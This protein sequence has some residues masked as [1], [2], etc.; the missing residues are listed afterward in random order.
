[1]AY[2][3]VKVDDQDQGKWDYKAF[4]CGAIPWTALMGSAIGMNRY[5]A[6]V[7]TGAKGAAAPVNLGQ[8]VH[9]PVNFQA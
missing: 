3:Y 9:A 6:L 4:N 2:R 1:M 7:S 5:R 8:Q